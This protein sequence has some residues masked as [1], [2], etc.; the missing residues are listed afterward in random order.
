MLLEP[1]VWVALAFLV[2]VVGLGYLGVHK[3]VIKAL[4]DRGD[5]IKAE[6]E[7]ASRLKNEAMAVLA[8]Y[9]RRRG[10]AESEAQSIVAMAQADAERLA[11]EAKARIE[12]FV[13]RRTKLA[14]AKI[15]QAES[16]AMADVRSAA[17]EA[18]V[19][20]AERILIQEVKGSLGGTLIA[21][22]ID[23]VG[24]KLN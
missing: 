8:E 20:A 18:A 24:K 19:A 9:Q 16:Q 22:G 3:K 15:A 12:E 7:E 6:L 23:D 11:V 5:R 10:E 13:E 4:D 17:A 1:E 21:K 2:F 14:E